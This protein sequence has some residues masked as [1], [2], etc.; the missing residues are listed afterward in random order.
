MKPS[1]EL[2]GFIYGLAT[3]SRFANWL[4]QYSRTDM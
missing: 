3:A 4:L 1:M 2:I